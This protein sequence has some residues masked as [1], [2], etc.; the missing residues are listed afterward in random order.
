MSSSYLFY[1]LWSVTNMLSVFNYVTGPWIRIPPR[2]A[3]LGDP[4][5]GFIWF[6]FFVV[7]LLWCQKRAPRPIIFCGWWKEL[8]GFIL[9]THHA[10]TMSCRVSVSDCRWAHP[11]I[12]RPPSRDRIT[13]Q[14]R[15]PFF[16]IDS[17][18]L[19][20]KPVHVCCLQGLLYVR[21]TSLARFGPARASGFWQCTTLDLCSDSSRT[22][23]LLPVCCKY[24]HTC[25][26]CMGTLD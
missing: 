5:R 13:L 12:L 2:P 20:K 25:S 8:R 1:C 21:V 14:V 6:D 9:L 11:A 10:K 3:G 23:Q 22:K 15:D 18:C 16:C 24:Q 17:G 26:L 4:L 19:A 7:V